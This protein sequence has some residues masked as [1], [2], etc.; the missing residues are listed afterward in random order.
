M[1]NNIE[2]SFVGLSHLGLVS[3]ISASLKNF[4]VTAFDSDINKIKNFNRGV[5]DI[6]EPNLH[7]NYNKI[8]NK[9][10]FTYNKQ[11]LSNSDIIYFSLD[12]PTNRNNQSNTIKLKRMINT[13]LPVLKKKSIIIILSQVNPGFTVKINWPK[14]YLYYQVET[15]IFGNA[16]NRAL[17]PE[18]IIVGAFKNQIS[19][20]TY[21]YFL[22]KFSKKIIL[23]Y[24]DEAELTKIS[25]NLFLS[26]TI[27]ITNLIAQ[28]CENNKLSWKKIIPAL[29]L[30][31]RIGKYAYLQPGLGISGG[32]LERDLYSFKKLLTKSNINKDL[33]DSIIKF[34]ELR[35]NWVIDKLKSN[36]NDI[37]NIAILGVA[38]K[39]DT[40]SIKNSPTQ[41][42]INYINK[43]S[44]N[45]KLYDPLITKYKNYK[46]DRD[47]NEEI[48]EFECII[49][50]NKSKSF[51][52]INNYDIYT[53]KLKLLI[54]PFEVVNLNK[55][56]KTKFRTHVM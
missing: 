52:N 6:E 51:Y 49:I 47:L 10:N 26:S 44:I 23:M 14:D 34:S 38:Y 50:M 43:Y 27:S 1:K 24:Y 31:K 45:V 32:N 16:F 7:K 39:E 5:F 22:R 46:I 4:K 29:K 12:V 53:S 3:A 17:H 42:I 20:K 13:I 35:K 19:S 30:D 28:F 37:K 25:I 55:N 33:I 11:N 54:D 21:E 15:L 40:N 48:Q 41:A 2:I 36:I 9:I 8:K 56:R 18:R